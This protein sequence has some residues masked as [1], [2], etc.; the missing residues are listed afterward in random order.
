[1]LPGINAFENLAASRYI[2][3]SR[4]EGIGENT[5]YMFANSNDLPY[6]SPVRALQQSSIPRRDIDR[7][8]MGWVE[9]ERTITRSLRDARVQ[10]NACPGLCAVSRLEDAVK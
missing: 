2:Q 5:F 1:M 7:G 6:P 9:S 4:V 10:S 3:E 8:R